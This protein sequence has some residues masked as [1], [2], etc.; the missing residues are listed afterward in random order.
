[1]PR[2]MPSALHCWF[3]L[4]VN[5]QCNCN[6]S[7]AYFP[8]SE[9]TC[10]WAFAVIS[11]GRVD[12]SVCSRRMHVFHQFICFTM[13]ICA[14]LVLLLHARISELTIMDAEDAASKRCWLLVLFFIFLNLILVCIFST[15]EY[16]DFWIT[17]FHVFIFDFIHFYLLLEREP[18][19]SSWLFD[20]MYLLFQMKCSAV[21]F[22]PFYRICKLA[23]NRMV[24]KATFVLTWT[25]KIYWEV[26]SSETFNV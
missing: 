16:S 15:Y 25:G 11:N 8:Y 6:S 5:L 1:M 20:I 4:R 24:W 2:H 18:A 13:L 21:I 9:F 22:D 19:S 17:A 26:Y 7:I 10:W 23:Y 12:R 3:V 14:T